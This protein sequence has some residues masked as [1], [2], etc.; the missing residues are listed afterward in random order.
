MPCY[1]Y[2][3][4]EIE[5]LKNRDE[6]LGE[7][8]ER[9]GMI[10]RQVNPDLFAALVSSVIAQQISAKAAQTVWDRLEGELGS[11]TAGAVCTTTLEDLQKCGL[12]PRKVGYVKG[13]GELVQQ[14]HLDLE[15]IA[16]LPDDEVVEALS[17]LPGVGVWTA[18]MM[19]IFSLRRPDVVSWGDLAI[20][21]GMMRLYRLEALQRKDFDRYRRRYAPFGTVASLYLWH[22]SHER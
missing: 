8:I 11:V 5:H 14:G 9:I 6:R 19:L 7:A 2:G 18:E 16:R 1:E 21:R 3:A 20:R 15:A 4:V 12:S 17:A 22:L 10:E 13:I